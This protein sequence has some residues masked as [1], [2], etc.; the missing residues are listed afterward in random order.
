MP[1]FDLEANGKTFEIEAPDQASALAAFQTVATGRSAA[2]E[3][4]LGLAKSGGV[5]LAKGALGIAGLVGDA[6]SLGAKGIE[7]ATNYVADKLGIERY[8]RPQSESVLNS[9]PTSASLQKNVES[10]TGPFYKPQTT[11]EKYAETVG[12]FA[13]AIISGPGGLARRALSQ[14]AVPGIASEAAGQYTAG[15]SYEPWARAGAALLAPAGVNAAQRMVTPLP[16]SAERQRLLGI[17]N[18]EGVT[19]LTAGQRSGNKTLQYAES[20]L[21]DAPGAGQGASHIQQEGQRQFTEAA[22]RRAGAGPSATP[23]VLAQNNARLGNEFEALSARNNLVPDNQFITDLT[24]AVRDYRNVPPSQQRQ[25]VQGYVDDIIQHVNAGN[26]PGPQYQ[27]MR[28]R[29]SR[30]SQ[31]L[32]QSDPTLSDALRDMRNAL[33][34]AMGRSIPAADQ[35]AWQTARREYGAQKTLEQ[36]ASRAGEATTEG[37]IVPANLRNAAAANNRG[38]Y[39]RGQGDFSELARAGSGVM[40]PLP[41]SGT[42]QRNQINNMAMLSAALLG[43]GAGSVGGVSGMMAGMAAGTAA[44]ALLG[45]AL[46]S[47]PMQAYLSNQLLAAPAA[48]RRRI[49]SAL[50]REDAALPAHRRPEQIENRR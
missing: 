50:L 27:E 17:L 19:S 1:V 35:Q 47:A 3:T 42:G 39:A 46:M 32:R 21:G 18:D 23:E 33:D 26:M 30:Q 49:L 14:V 34:D 28:S 43:G 8:Q 44:P 31:A 45:R 16:V 40:A 41:N 36:A 9:I 4:A 29:L 13:P 37:Q 10:V 6:S 48:D 25:M 7:T 22:M 38:A 5:G 24:T 11:A 2:A 15:T 12:E 20:I